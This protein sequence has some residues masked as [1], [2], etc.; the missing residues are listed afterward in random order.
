VIDDFEHFAATCFS[1]F[2]DRVSLW[3]TLN[4]PWCSA[5]LGYASGEMAPG[6]KEMPDSE[7]YLAA[8][9]MLL[10]HARAVRRYRQ[11]FQAAQGGQIGISLN[12]AW[13]EP[14]TSSL[15]DREAAQRALDWSCGW[16][17]DPI[18]QGDYPES[19][20]AR[21]GERLPSFTEAERELLRG[22][23]DFFG[24]NHYTTSYAS[25][26]ARGAKPSGP[27]TYFSEQ[28]VQS[29][30]DP[31]WP[32]TDMDWAVVPWGLRR[33]C[34]YIQRR[35]APAHGLFVT[36][37]GCAARE[38][39]AA[40]AKEDA[41]RVEYLRAY[42]AQLHQAIEAGADVRG[43]FAW[44]FMD[45][46]E[47]AYGYGKRFGLVRVDYKTQERSVKASGRMFAE[48]AR[49]N[50]LRISAQLLAASSF[51]R[52]RDCD[53]QKAKRALWFKT[54]TEDAYDAWD[55]SKATRCIRA[56]QLVLGLIASALEQLPVDPSRVYIMGSSLGGYGA[57]RL[58][59]LA[60]ALPAAVV[61]MAGY[62]PDVPGQDHDAARLAERLR[63]V[64]RVWPLHCEYD[65]TC[66]RDAPEVARLYKC[67]RETL[68]VKVDPVPYSLAR[69]TRSD[70]HWAQR[71]VTDD[72]E[73]FFGELLR[74]SRSPGAS[75]ADLRHRIDALKS[76]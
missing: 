23:S 14:L 60:P 12:V 28:G 42:V 20:R 24:L 4:E 64:P 9:H 7:P 49:T 59:E 43:Y 8:H 37:N 55:F 26:P 40:E 56:E 29:T 66:R 75:A 19:M 74:I 10:A 27:R 35:Y 25:A 71:A 50:A 44:S 16:F 30:D 32:R 33:L 63:G 61:P 51:R 62:Y 65:K 72:P 15:G 69:G 2:G 13:H 31:R 38:R 47:W 53:W 45:N 70:Y 52:I 34:E 39:T 67:L 18:W 68:G 48:L 46:F 3:I 41:L 21:C 1:N 36:E 5:A 11:E 6:R 76:L 22:S 54:M 17:A 73:A 57:L 58:A